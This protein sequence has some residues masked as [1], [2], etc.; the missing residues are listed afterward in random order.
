VQGLRQEKGKKK[1]NK[2]NWGRKERKN[3][4]GCETLQPKRGAQRGKKKKPDQTDHEG[5]KKKEKGGR[6]GKGKEKWSFQLAL[7]ARG[8]NRRNGHHGTGIK[9]PNERRKKKKK[10]ESFHAK[11]QNPS[12]SSTENKGKRAPRRGKGDPTVKKKG[13]GNYYPKKRKAQKTVLQGEGKGGQ[14]LFS[15]ERVAWEVLFV[16]T[17]K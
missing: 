7:H 9:Y 3:R 1:E 2:I 17:G 13:K 14:T 5:E 4:G 10:G 8:A 6:G 11:Q 15:K 12:S 16:T